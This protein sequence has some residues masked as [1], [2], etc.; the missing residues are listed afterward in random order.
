MRIVMKKTI[1]I[2][3]VGVVGYAMYQTFKS[4]FDVIIYDKYKLHFNTIKEE[5]PIKE[6][7]ALMDGPIFLCVPTPIKIDG[8]CDISI[9]EELCQKINDAQQQKIIEQS[10]YCNCIGSSEQIV[11]IRSTVCPQTCENLAS[12]YPYISI[13]YNP[14]FLTERTAI[15]DFRTTKNIVLGGEEKITQYVASFYKE[16]FKDINCFFTSTTK[17]EIL[18]YVVNSFFALKI[19]FANQIKLFC[20]SIDVDYNQLKE[21]FLTECRLGN[22]HWDVPGHDGLYG[23]GGK[24]LPKDILGFLKCAEEKNINLSLLQEVIEINN[25]IRYK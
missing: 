10:N 24:C 1:G 3:G 11:V 13:V 12:K 5:N 16:V 18:K 7:V 20:D 19:I 17:A 6:F 8:S 25:S 22:S 9:V 4:F 15:D 2:I 14:E 21:L 23:F